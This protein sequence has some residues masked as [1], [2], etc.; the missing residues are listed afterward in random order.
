M[1]V[2]FAV[3]AAVALLASFGCATNR[4]AIPGAPAP[5]AA[6]AQRSGKPV[7]QLQQGYAVYML[8][9]GECHERKLPDEITGSRWHAVV[10]G[11]AWNAGLSSTDEEALLA[12]LT[13]VNTKR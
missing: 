5:D 8:K 13:A 9:C 10:P 1:R 4:Q 11:M 3:A 2:K 12:Y 7:A 6:L